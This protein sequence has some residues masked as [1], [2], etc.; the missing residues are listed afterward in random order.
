MDMS[1]SK[2]QKTALYSSGCSTSYAHAYKII[3]STKFFLM[4]KDLLQIPAEIRSYIAILICGTV[5]LFGTENRYVEITDDKDASSPRLQMRLEFWELLRMTME[6]DNADLFQYFLCKG[7]SLI[8]KFMLHFYQDTKNDPSSCYGGTYSINAPIKLTEEQL[9]NSTIR[10]LAKQ[11]NLL[12]G[13][14][15]PILLMIYL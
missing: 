12:I 10:S 8:S 13:G 15:L 6:G 3:A 5:K 11:Y 9:K 7:F 4:E 1:I 14:I 2:E